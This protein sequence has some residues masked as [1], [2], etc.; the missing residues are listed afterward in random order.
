[1]LDELKKTLEIIEGEINL[2]YR[3]EIDVNGEHLSLV[4]NAVE[5]EL[6]K[7][8]SGI[9]KSIDRYGKA[10]LHQLLSPWKLELEMSSQKYM[11]VGRLDKLIKIGSEI[12]PSMIKTSSLP[13]Y[14]VWYNDRIQLAAYS[15]LVEE[16]F[17]VAIER[18]MVEYARSGTLREITIKHS[19][20]RKVLEIRD[21]VLRI[22]NGE[23]PERISDSNECK[24]CSYKAS[25]ESRVSLASKFFNRLENSK[26]L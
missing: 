5:V 26:I 17:D 9:K 14:G 13:E 6:P 10:Q 24:Y 20:R 8:A 3:N 12:I 1:L 18:G 2:I 19:D 21:K 22:K 7:I 15:I 4:K 11:L 16:K 25:C 23:F